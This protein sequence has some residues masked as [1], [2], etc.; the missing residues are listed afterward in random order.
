M[1]TVTRVLA[2]IPAHWLHRQPDFRTLAK[3]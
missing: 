3:P 1:T 2:L